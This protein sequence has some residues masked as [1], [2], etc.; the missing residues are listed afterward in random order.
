MKNFFA[1]LTAILLISFF[2]AS[3][4]HA[5]FATK[6]VT[7]LGGTI[8]YSSTTAV[9][10]GTTASETTSL[11]QF[12][13]YANYYIVDGFSL[14]ISPGINIWKFAGASES[15]KGYA[16]FL[17]PG[18]TF[19][20]KNN[21]YPFIEGMIGYTA[22][23]GGSTDLSGISFGGKG[24]VKFAVGNNGLVTAGLSYML[25]NLSPSGADKRSGYN[26]LAFSFGYSVFIS[27]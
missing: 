2:T 19:T 25:F 11:F 18:Y 13:P 20:T 24:G 16:I 10:N 27:R 3:N 26:N 7:E 1:L 22:I 8:S 12:M 9:S 15:M 5:Q 21:I 14:G 4:V 17:V 6:G 23:S